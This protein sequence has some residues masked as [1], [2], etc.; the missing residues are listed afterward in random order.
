MPKPGQGQ[1]KAKKRHKEIER[2]RKAREKMVR[3]QTKKE[4]DE[5]NAAQSDTAENTTD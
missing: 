2:Q 4:E 5:K 3:R 1:H